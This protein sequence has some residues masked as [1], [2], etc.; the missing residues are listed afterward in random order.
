MVGGNGVVS[1]AGIPDD[2]L[3]RLPRLSELAV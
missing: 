1:M 3:L 2:R